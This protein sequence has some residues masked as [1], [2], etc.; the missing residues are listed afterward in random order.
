MTRHAPA[1]PP[2]TTNP[3]PHPADAADSAASGY[4]GPPNPHRRPPR[5]RRRAAAAMGVTFLYAG[6]ALAY[7]VTT[8]GSHP[9]TAVAGTLSAPT[10]GAQN[11]AATPSSIPIT[12]MP[13]GGYTPTGYTVLRCTGSSCTPTTAITSGGC[14]GTVSG[15]SCTDT[16]TKLAAGRTYTYAVEAQFSNWVSSASTSFQGA[17]TSATQLVFTGQPAP[18]ASI[19]AAGTGSFTVSVAVE[20]AGGNL[21]SHD[22]SDAVTLAIAGGHNPGGGALSCTGGLTAPVSAG[23]A[24]FTGCAITKTGSG[25]QLTASST[26]NPSLTAPANAHSFDITAGNAA[27]VI[28]TSGGGQSAAAAVAFT[29]P[30]VATVED[31]NGN[32]VAGA[33]LTFTGPT[34]GASVTFAASGCTANPQTYSCVASTG[35]DGQATSSAFTANATLGSYTIS[36]SAAGAGSASFSE[37][38]V[39][40]AITSLAAANGSGGTAGEIDA[41]DT[42]TVGFSGQIDASKVCSAWTNASTGTQTASSAVVT[43][44]DPGSG[45]DVLRFTTAPTGCS[46]FHFGHIDLGSDGYVLPDDQGGESA[47]FSDSAISYNG[48]T[49]T[50]QITLGTLSLSNGGQLGTVPSSALTLTLSPSVLDTGENSLSSYTYATAPGPQF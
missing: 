35:A 6:A 14:G 16:D 15:T 22:N 40:T 43:V 24:S 23:V 50:L 9:A 20:D 45:D 4:Q 26:T 33:P 2:E 7:W 36:A 8:D 17:T 28:A 32:P 31:V 49:N 12:W 13:P 1:P 34:S 37:S 41:N 46:T 18:G 39:R 21:A 38:N 27:Q 42:I 10:S 44:T 5:Q 48:T 47:A 29:S 19:Q 25:Y 30:L 11:G 3:Q